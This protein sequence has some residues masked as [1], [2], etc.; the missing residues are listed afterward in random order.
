MTGTKLQGTTDSIQSIKPST[1]LLKRE[2]IGNRRYRGGLWRPKEPLG[3]TKNDKDPVRPPDSYSKGSGPRKGK[4]PL[5]DPK[6]ARAMA[7]DFK[8]VTPTAI[9]FGDML[10]KSVEAWEVS[11]AKRLRGRSRAAQ[12][13]LSLAAHRLGA[14]LLLNAEEDPERWG[15]TTQDTSEFSDREVSARQ[16][17]AVRNAF[18]AMG[19]L[20]YRD[21]F[22]S[23]DFQEQ[24]Q[25]FAARMRATPVFFSLAAK[26]GLTPHSARQHYIRSLPSKPLLLKAT[27]KHGANGQKVSGRRI[28]FERTGVAKQLEDDVKELNGFLDQ[29]ELKG[30]VHRGY[31]RIFNLGDDPSFSWNKGGRL[32]SQGED[33]Y[34]R[35]PS[36]ERLKMTIDDEPVVEIDIRSSYLTIYYAL[37]ERALDQ[38]TDPYE[39]SGIPRPVAKAWTTMT[40][41]HD[42]FHKRW[43]KR[44]KTDL[45]E[46]GFVLKG[47]L[48]IKNV[49]AAMLAA[50]P[51]LERWP[52]TQYSWADLM[53]VESCAIMATSLRLYHDH[54]V[55]CFS[56]HDSII[57]PVSKQVLAERVLKDAYEKVCGEAPVLAAKTAQ[58]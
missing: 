47:D 6:R 31:H 20:L 14:D 13:A 4:L 29:F 48:S 24:R 12:E 54:W 3:D 42:K 15:Y 38:S 39:R 19:F 9:E 51:V 2:N 43:H 37:L 25:G 1:L 58:H 34:Q 35:L 23:A 50:H 32:Y 22:S 53:F 46:K 16:F 21:G 5:N 26:A 28:D 18:I 57:V 56:V 41:G 36:A 52:N 55:P 11:E 40:F 17:R 45:E 33:C 49:E 30:G 10:V 8:S 7:L 27:A 44:A